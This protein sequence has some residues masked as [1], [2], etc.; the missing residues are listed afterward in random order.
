VKDDEIIR[1]VDDKEIPEDE[2]FN[3]ED[4]RVFGHFLQDKNDSHGQ[5]E[6]KRHWILPM[7]K[8]RVATKIPERMTLVHNEYKQVSQEGLETNVDRMIMGDQPS[9]SNDDSRF[10]NN[11][12]E[13]SLEAACN[14]LGDTENDTPSDPRNGNTGLFLCNSLPAGSAAAIALS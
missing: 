11:S 3:S 12:D 9:D 10:D 2:A 13:D 14:A 5:R 6:K 4:E 1:D 8:E 7:T